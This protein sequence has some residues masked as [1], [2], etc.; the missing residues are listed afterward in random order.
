MTWTEADI[1]PLLHKRYGKVSMGSRRYSVAEHPRSAAHYGVTRI[2]DFVAQDT[3]RTFIDASGEPVGY[4]RV[5][6]RGDIRYQ[7]HGHEVKVTRTDWLKELAD[8]SKSEEWKQYCDRWWLVAPAGVLRDG[9]LPEGWGYMQVVKN[10]VR[11]KVNAPRLDPKPMEAETRSL[12]MR[13]VQGTAIKQA[14]RLHDESYDERQAV[15]PR[16]TASPL[17]GQ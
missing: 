3:Y 13:A 4:P 11:V 15:A 1:L 8:L 12:L 17:L 7:M 2:A 9:E 5:P 14:R 16:W 6:E 10:G